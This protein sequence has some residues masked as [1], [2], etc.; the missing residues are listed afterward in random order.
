M[1]CSV[2]PCTRHGLEK[3][4][5]LLHSLQLQLVVFTNYPSPPLISTRLTLH[6]YLDPQYSSSGL[7]SRLFCAVFACD[8]ILFQ[9]ITSCHIM[10]HLIICTV[11]FHTLFLFLTFLICPALLH[12]THLPG[13]LLIVTVV[14]LSTTC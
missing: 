5:E 8:S 4:H 10:S 3:Q 11:G 6:L 1:S 2:T 9:S 12:P 13:V 14:C 7:C